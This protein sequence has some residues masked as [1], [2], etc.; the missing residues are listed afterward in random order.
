MTYAGATRAAI[1]ELR[2]ALPDHTG[3]LISAAD[4]TMKH[5][6]NLLGS[7]WFVPDDPARPRRGGYQPIDWYLDPVRALRFPV[8]VP[9]KQWNLYEMRPGNADVKYPWEL[10][11]CQHWVTLAQAYRLTGNQTYADEIALQLDDFVEANPVGIGINWTCTMDVGLRAVN[12]VIALDLVRDSALDADAWS[13]A[14]QALFDHGLFIRANLENNYEVTSNHFLSN[15]LGLW[16]LAS[17]FDDLDDGRA[18][19]EFARQALET[20]IDVQVLPDGADFESSVPYHR[21]VTELFLGAARLGDLRGDVLSSHYRSRVRDMVSYLAAVTRPDGL[22]PQ[23]GDADDGRLHV[24][25]GLGTATPQDGRHLF[26]PASI[27]FAQPQWMALGGAAAAWEAA[28]WGFDYSAP[29]VPAM[30]TVGKLFADAGHAVGRRNGHYLLITNSVVGTKGFG[31]HKHNDQLS[32]EYHASG[33]PVIVDA[34]SYVYT[35]DPAARNA[36]RGTAIHNTVTV[37]GVEQNEFNPEWLFRTFEQAKAEHLAFA[38]DED[39]LRYRGR[40]VGYLRLPEGVAHER[41][42]DFDLRTGRLRIEDQLI[43]SG[44]HDL[45]WHFHLAPGIDASSGSSAWTLSGMGVSVRLIVPPDLQGAVEDTWYSP[46]YGRRVA[47]RAL[48]LSTRTRVTDNRWTF[49]FEPLP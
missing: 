34:G 7:G 39:T 47:C 22:M 23:S 19:G 17:M 37:D 33:Q 48:N 21:L 36:F 13:R 4:R 3:T 12:W 15:V 20:E 43:G 40:H 1:A 30:I 41:A 11:R 10:A 9:H 31:N 18:W 14:G 42:F 26:G 49:A 24:F 6:F 16:F 44:E 38:A 29:P 8:G 45:R 2:N 28:W 35:S 32:F 27:M 5:E 25:G 46:S